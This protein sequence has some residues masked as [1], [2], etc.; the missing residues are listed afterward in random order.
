M[1]IKL[2]ECWKIWSWMS[3]SLPFILKGAWKVVKFWT[4]IKQP[5][6]YSMQIKS[7]AP[8]AQNEVRLPLHCTLSPFEVPTFKLLAPYCVCRESRTF[9]HMFCTSLNI[10]PHVRIQNQLDLTLTTH[11]PSTKSAK[12]WLSS[13]EKRA[14]NYPGNSEQ[15]RIT[16]PA[17][18][19]LYPSKWGFPPV[20][21][22]CRESPAVFFFFFFF[23]FLFF[24]E[25][26]L[27]T[28]PQLDYLDSVWNSCV[29][30]AE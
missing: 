4:L 25:G 23:L 22:F 18:C 12:V 21:I 9:S 28:R 26:Q 7:M 2:M 1:N 19:R 24:K 29:R 3:H 13:C 30:T 15:V 17:A 20:R 27:Q 10:T 8:L 16:C 6:N 14:G 5:N 11:L